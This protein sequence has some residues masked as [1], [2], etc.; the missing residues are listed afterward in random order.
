MNPLI[1]PLTN[2]EPVDED[3]AEQAVPGHG[4]PSQELNAAAQTAPEPHEAERE[5]NSVMMG[6][7]VVA[8]VA[9]REGAKMQKALEQ[10]LGPFFDQ[11]TRNFFSANGV[12]QVT[13]SQR[14]AARQSL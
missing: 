8:D 7:G 5:A 10:D 4:I 13:E 2:I 9:I 11:F 6:G 12:F 3:M 1:T 14:S